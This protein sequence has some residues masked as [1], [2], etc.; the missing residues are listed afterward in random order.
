MQNLCPAAPGDVA[1]ARLRD[2]YPYYA[3]LREHA[4]VFPERKPNGLTVWHVTRYADVHDLLADRRLTKRP[5]SVGAGYVSGP[6]GLQ[7]HLVHADPPEH[8]RLRRLANQAF[9]A[10]RVAALTPLVE[11]MARDLIARFPREGAVDVIGD[12]AFPFAY[13]LIR[14]VLGVPGH[15]DTPAARDLLTASLAPV[16]GAPADL[17]AGLHAWLT[18]LIAHKRRAGHASGDLLGVL[19]DACDHGDALTEHELI[20]TAYILLLVG[21]D[22]TVNLIGNGTLALLEH[23]AQWDRLRSDPG[24]VGTAVEE[25]LRYDS[26][27]RKATFRAATRPL[28]LHDVTIPAGD[29]VSLAIGSANRDGARFADPDELDLG[30]DPNPHLALGRGPHF[31]IGATLA[32]MEAAIAFPLL[33]ERLGTAKLAVAPEDLDWRPSRIMRGLTRLPVLPG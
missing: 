33:L 12:F 18:E 31:C 4:P 21:H 17:D 8:T 9:T 2:P 24:L 27:V 1:A 20:S 26:P 29:V 3:W 28:D 23:P 25:L 30:R 7:Q 19:V 6:A 10:R 13:D 32:R 16:A 22:T 11:G 14:T 15:L 5:A